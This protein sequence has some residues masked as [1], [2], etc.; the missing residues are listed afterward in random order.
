MGPKLDLFLSKGDGVLFSGEDATPLLIDVLQDHNE[1]LDDRVFAARTIGEYA[2][3]DDDAFELLIDLVTNEEEPVELRGA[4]AIGMGPALEVC[5]I[6]GFDEF[7]TAPI[8]EPVYRRAKATLRAV[9]S[10]P[11]APKEV[12]RRALE[13]SVRAPEEWHGEAVRRAWASDDGEWKQTAVFA[14]GYVSGF[15]QHIVE[16]LGSEDE[17]VRLEAVRAAGVRALK[18]AWPTVR[19]IIRS[20]TSDRDLLRAA[21]EA[22]VSIDPCRAR[23]L[24]DRFFDHEDPEIAEAAREAAGLAEVMDLDDFL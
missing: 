21:I 13:A 14:M 11:D 18:E 7:E 22:A 1:P 8:S 6:D 3:V 19:S 16:T 24:L 4:A 12:R 15:D 17:G 9:Y 20:N 5:D 10:D 23:K 2:F